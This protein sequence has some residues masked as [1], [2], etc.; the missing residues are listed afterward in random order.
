MGGN[1]VEKTDIIKLALEL[2]SALRDSDEIKAIM[3]AQERLKADL[4]ASD[5]LMR[6][7]DAKNKM[8]NKM[9]DGLIISD[10]EKNHLT[11]IEQQMRSNALV[12]ELMSVQGNFENLMQAVY[13]AMN[14]ALAGG[15][16][17]DCSSC[18][19]GCG[20]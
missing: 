16:P 3:V 2:G 17:S 5:L 9:R 14:Q 11:I 15:C 8:E 10:A 13:Y 7:Q 19:G 18:G 4:E 20:I 1:C 6:F 12:S